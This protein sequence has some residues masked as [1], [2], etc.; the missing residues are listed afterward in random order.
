VKTEAEYLGERPPVLLLSQPRTLRCRAITGTR[1][2]CSQSYALCA[3]C[4]RI[5]QVAS[6][7][8]SATRR[9][10][11]SLRSSSAA[12]RS[13]EG[14]PGGSGIWRAIPQPS[15]TARNSN[16]G[17]LDRANGDL[18]FFMFSSR[19]ALLARSAGSN[20]MRTAASP[21]RG[22]ELKRLQRETGPS[23]TVSVTP[24]QAEGCR[25][26][27][28]CRMNKGRSAR[29]GNP[30]RCTWK[31]TTIRADFVG[32]T[33]FHQVRVVTRRTTAGRGGTSDHNDGLRA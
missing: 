11:T 21:C 31:R 10:T 28:D 25:V 7:C 9:R 19:R 8:G 26:E 29:I 1:G 22:F 18:F 27:R 13:L 6:Q 15:S 24:D 14:S 32:M 12:Q 4:E 2:W 20:P 3:T 17:P 33:Q 5:R 16:G 23:T 30:F